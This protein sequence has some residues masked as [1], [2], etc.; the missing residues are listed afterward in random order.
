MEMLKK[1]AQ[2]ERELYNRLI[3]PTDE[4]TQ[5]GRIVEKHIA[6]GLVGMGV[7]IAVKSSP[8]I[9]AGSLL[10]GGLIF[11]SRHLSKK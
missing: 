3:D 11:I 9:G 4:I 6:V 8:L 2:K 1:V 7:L 10:A 5:K